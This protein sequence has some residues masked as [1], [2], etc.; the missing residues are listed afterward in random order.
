MILN[1]TRIHSLTELTS[2]T[3]FENNSCLSLFYKEMYIVEIKRVFH[4]I[5]L[6][7]ENESVQKHEVGENWYSVLAE[8][9]Y[10]CLGY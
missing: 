2:H 6:I 8:V 9:L 5:I 4:I 3:V 7:F 10:L 1:K